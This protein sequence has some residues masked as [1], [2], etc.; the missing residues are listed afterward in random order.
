MMSH[1]FVENVVKQGY[2]KKGAYGTSRLSGLFR[3]NEVNKWFVFTIRQGTPF[4]EYYNSEVDVFI[5]QPINS[6]NLSNCQNVKSMGHTNLPSFCIVCPERVI[7]LVASSRTQML[8]WVHEVD[9][10]LTRLGILQN[11]VVD[12]VY[13]VCPAVV[14]KPRVSKEL[15]DENEPEILVSSNA[16]ESR[17]PDETSGNPVASSSTDSLSN[18][19]N[20]SPPP[21]PRSSPSRHRHLSLKTSSH[22]PLANRT[23]SFLRSSSHASSSGLALPPPLPIRQHSHQPRI[24]SQK[25]T[26]EISATVPKENPSVHPETESS[27]DSDFVSAELIEELWQQRQAAM[28]A[29]RPASLDSDIETNSATPLAM[30]KDINIVMNKSYFECGNIFENRLSTSQKLQVALEPVKILS[31]SKNM[32]QSSTSVDDSSAIT[33]SPSPQ[34]ILLVDNLIR[35]DDA[36]EN[37]YCAFPCQQVLSD[38]SIS[39]NENN[40]G[41]SIGSKHTPV[42]RKPLPKMSSVPSDTPSE[43][44]VNEYIIPADG[45]CSDEVVACVDTDNSMT[46]INDSVLNEYVIC[47]TICAEPKLQVIESIKVTDKDENTHETGSCHSQQSSVKQFES[48][49]SKDENENFYNPAHD[50]DQPPTTIAPPVPTLPSLSSVPPLPPRQNS[51][52][53]K[54]EGSKLMIIPDLKSSSSDARN[55]TTPPLPPSAFSAAASSKHRSLPI[56]SSTV[57]PLLLPRKSGT[58]PDSLRKPQQASAFASSGPVEIPPMPPRRASPHVSPIA[59]DDHPPAVPSR[60]SQ[61]FFIKR[62]QLTGLSS[63]MKSSCDDT[64]SPKSSTSENHVGSSES[65]H[66]D[67][68]A[69]SSSSNLSRKMLLDRA[70]SLHT[71]VSLKQTQAEILQSEISMSCVSVS[72]TQKAGHGIALVDW[73]NFPCVAG[74]NQKDFPSLHGK[75]HLGDLIFS[76]NDVSVTTSEA[77]QK[78]LKHPS[79]SSSSSKIEINL[80]RMPYAKVFAIHR[81]AEGQSLGIKREGGTGEIVYVDPNGLA[82]QHGLTSYAPS[83]AGSGRSNWFLT[84]VNNRPLNLFFKENEIDLRLLAVGREISLVVQP[85]DF[86]FEIRRQFKKIK[87]YKNF[88]TQ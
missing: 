1:N 70:H 84:E 33:E 20:L 82:A 86:I 41:E 15:S 47:D 30:S 5:Q 40:S 27:N 52:N 12:H 11:E 88:I 87:N 18:P 80:H 74:W 23:S 16:S 58:N 77:A 64:V 34:N 7:E 45:V 6:F 49:R 61:S 36:V 17:H 59:Q 50:D 62:P 4:L 29:L 13:T 76:I 56:D 63:N 67:S 66:H 42:T 22:P 60:N 2:L 39:I 25:E 53:A 57:P 37:D 79:S 31:E 21:P 65:T 38:S 72:I 26:E 19:A 71:V 73:N 48:Y 44:A 3:R 81:N 54:L 69:A 51:H 75:L 14:R 43:L 28:R 46:V 10:S 85:C 55:P 9:A 83:A 35:S 32:S 78:L 8:E 68:G 24:I